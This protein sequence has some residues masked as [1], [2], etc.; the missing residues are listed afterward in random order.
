M[1]QK[2]RKKLTLSYTISTGLILTAI[3]VVLAFMITR[4]SSLQQESLFNSQFLTLT[5]RLQYDTAIS[6]NWLSTMET[7]NHLI[8]HICEND[9]PLLYT[10]ALHTSTDREI[11]L[12]KAEQAAQKQSI[13]LHTRPISTSM[14]STDLFTIKGKHHDTYRGSA[15]VLSTST[16]YLSLILLQDITHQKLQHRLQI[17]LFAL[18]DIIGIGLLAIVSWFFVG[19]SLVPIQENEKRQNAFI[20]AASH[21][22]RSPLAVIYTTADAIKGETQNDTHFI[23]TIKNECTRM[24]RLVQDLLLLASSKTKTITLQKETLDLDTLLLNT[25]ERYEPLCKQ[26]QFHLTLDL[27][28]DCLPNIRSDGARITQILSIFLDNGMTYA[29]KGSTLT[30]QAQVE[31]HHLRFSVIDH[32]CG[33]PDAEKDRVFENFYRS[34]SSHNAKSHF[35]L[36]LSVALE[37]SS[38]LGGKV[39]L[40]DTPGGGCT[41]S[42]LL[43]KKIE[44]EK[45]D[46][47]S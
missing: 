16:G 12:S 39:A 36:G 37:L 45:G 21:E 7:E 18:A 9:I 1:L 42:L 44:P 29:P 34:D 32:G 22:L 25:Y 20:A 40:T 13:D 31:K 27:P 4:F 3:L 28:D 47:R 38:Q 43:P 24:S 30:I 41:F 14:H 8:I 19:R 15:L 35:G 6:Q 11:L 26:R 23:Q 10:G 2:L 5:N 33:I 46:T 17:V